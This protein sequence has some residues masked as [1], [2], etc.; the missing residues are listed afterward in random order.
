MIFFSF[1]S[2]FFFISLIYA[3]FPYSYE[4]NF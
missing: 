4:I 2:G 3:F 1:V